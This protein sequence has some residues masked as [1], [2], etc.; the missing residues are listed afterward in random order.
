MNPTPS[1]TEREKRVLVLNGQNGVRRGET[2]RFWKRKERLY[3]SGGQWFFR[4][5]EGI[6]LG[7][8]RTEFEAEVEVDLL[9]E[10]L[11]L[12][13]EGQSLAVIRS[14]LLESM[15]DHSEAPRQSDGYD[16]GTLAVSRS[17]V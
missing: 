8:Y 14:F 7:P 10:H 4:T 3:C 5:R 2:W 15:L 11:K 1:A 9:K 13:P 6:D 16:I 17:S 12:A